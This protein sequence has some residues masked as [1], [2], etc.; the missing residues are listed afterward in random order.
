MAKVQEESAAKVTG[1]C[2]H[3]GSSGFVVEIDFPRRTQVLGVLLWVFSVVSVLALVVTICLPAFWWW[4]WYVVCA[5]FVLTLSGGLV[6]MLFYTPRQLTC[7]SCLES[8]FVP[9]RRKWFFRLFERVPHYSL[10]YA[11]CPRCGGRV[12]V[13][14]TV[15]HVLTSL[16]NE[17][18]L[19]FYLFLAFFMFFA[20]YVWLF[21]GW[22]DIDPILYFGR[23]VIVVFP[24]VVFYIWLRLTWRVYSYH[25][26]KCGNRNS[27]GAFIPLRAEAL[28]RAPS[29]RI[30]R[31]LGLE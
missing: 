17:L 9:D 7:Q 10:E 2:P 4:G 24:V 31:L 8:L 19:E 29:Q 11:R 27:V 16:A 3:C 21:L 20:L 13:K 12:G 15:V 23:M 18:L 28:S 6:V 25:C 14:M 26:S 1:A 5:W 30:R 22:Y